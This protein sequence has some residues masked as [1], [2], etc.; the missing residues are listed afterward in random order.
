MHSNDNS[1]LHRVRRE[2]VKS[3]NPFEYSMEADTTNQA[4][5]KHVLES[6]S[7]MTTCSVYRV[8]Q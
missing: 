6:V 5:P 2:A 4:I 7:H 3:R 8:V 1:L